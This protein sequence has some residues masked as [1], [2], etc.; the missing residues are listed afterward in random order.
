M[1]TETKRIHAVRLIRDYGIGKQEAKAIVRHN[2]KLG[3]LD[4][5]IWKL[6]KD[7]EK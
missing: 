2:V 3:T 4:A 7:G 6:S 5:L 1:L